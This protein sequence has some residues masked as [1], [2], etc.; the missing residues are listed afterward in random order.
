MSSVG[1]NFKH[2]WSILESWWWGFH[3]CQGGYLF[4]LH[5]SKVRKK[6]RRISSNPAYHSFDHFTT[7]FLQKADNLYKTIQRLMCIEMGKFVGE[8]WCDF[9]R[10][11]WCVARGR[12]HPPKTRWK[13]CSWLC[14]MCINNWPVPSWLCG[15]LFA[16]VAKSLWSVAFLWLCCGLSSSV[17]AHFAMTFSQVKAQLTTERSTYGSF[18]TPYGCFSYDFAMVDNCYTVPHTVCKDTPPHFVIAFFLARSIKF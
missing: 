5:A 13:P 3:I 8:F 9:H 1:Q 11:V 7:I 4:G 12:W 14:T 2:S 15:F 17:V 10:C 16:L 6:S 18:P